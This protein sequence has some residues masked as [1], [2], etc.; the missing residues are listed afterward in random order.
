MHL[1]LMQPAFLFPA[2]PLPPSPSP[3]PPA[4]GNS[5]IGVETIRAL[6][7]AG[8]HCILCSRS[9]AAG[10]AVADEIQP[11][12]KARQRGQGAGGQAGWMCSKAAAMS[13]LVLP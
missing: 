4:G 10:Q 8:A 12:V 3:F 13:Y 2:S 7:S 6:A 1:P 11:H 9:V 5:G